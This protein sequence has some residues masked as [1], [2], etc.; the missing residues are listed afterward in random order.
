MPFLVAE[1]GGVAVAVADVE[2]DE[3]AD[4]DADELEL[5][6]FCEEVEDEAVDVVEEVDAVV[7]DVATMHWSF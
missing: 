7:E 4:A 2:V 5:V 6:V 3:V 1:L